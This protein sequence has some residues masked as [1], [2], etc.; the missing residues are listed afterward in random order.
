VA[1]TSREVTPTGGD[2]ARPSTPMRFPGVNVVSAVA[3][4]AFPLLGW[5]TAVAAMRVLA[6]RTENLLFAVICAVFWLLVCLYSAFKVGDYLIGYVDVFFVGKS[7]YVRVAFGIA[8]LLVVSAIMLIVNFGI[9]SALDEL[10]SALR[11][12]S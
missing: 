3:E 1:V 5:C 10:V 12:K 4:L 2:T 8:Y 11:V 6:E 7:K 9:S